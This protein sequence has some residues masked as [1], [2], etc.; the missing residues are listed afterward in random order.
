MIELV[1][2][3]TD[4]DS[5]EIRLLGA[6]RYTRVGVIGVLSVF[7]REVYHRIDTRRF[8]FGLDWHRRAERG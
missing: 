5:V 3:T 2:R 1:K 4:G 7:G 6:I 8:L